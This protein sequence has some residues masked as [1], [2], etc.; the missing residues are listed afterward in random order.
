MKE[1]IHITVSKDGSLSLK[2]EGVRGSRCVS[3]TEIF[4]REIGDVVERQKTTDFYKAG[5]MVLRNRI[6]IQDLMA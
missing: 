1:Q 6:T 5:E 2:V 4:E 3:I